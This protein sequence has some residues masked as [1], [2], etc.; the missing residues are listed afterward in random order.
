MIFILYDRQSVVGSSMN[1][2]QSSWKLHNN[3]EQ[4]PD[5]PGI[6][7]IASLFGCRLRDFANNGYSFLVRRM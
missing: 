7:G 5:T 6:P 4:Q 1:H 3:D 2:S